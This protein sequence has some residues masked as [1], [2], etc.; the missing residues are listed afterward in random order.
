MSF[1]ASTSLMLS[2]FQAMLVEEDGKIKVRMRMGSSDEPGDKLEQGDLIIMMNGKRT[3][4]ITE[5][6]ELYESI[7]KDEE[8]KIGVQRGEQRFILSKIKG[9]APQ[10]GNR[11]VMRM[12]T[13]GDGKAPTVIPE[14]GFLLSDNEKTVTIQR[15]MNM[16]LPQEL[17]Y[18]DVD[19]TGF[20][21]VSIN[22]SKPEDAEHAK[23]MID[24]LSVGDEISFLFSNESDEISFTI[25]KPKVNSNINF[26]I[27]D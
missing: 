24:E 18:L 27:D 25:K 5:L 20:T 2:E 22:G 10:G 15:V 26:S 9:D 11:M 7:S 21:I 19:L 13:D 4:S 6:R 14:L 12:E 3:K 16:M 17:K 1:D 23:K 8:V